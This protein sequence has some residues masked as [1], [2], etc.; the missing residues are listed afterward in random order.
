MRE[1]LGQIVLK[2]KMILSCDYGAAGDN[3]PAM[4]KPQTT[5]GFRR[6]FIERTRWARIGR[7]Y[8]QEEAASLL[9]LPQDKYKQYESRSLLPHELIAKFC[10]LCA[11]DEGWLFT[12]KGRAPA[13]PEPPRKETRPRP[14]RRR[15]KAA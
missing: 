5:T 7:G 6:D 11:I 10:L 8:T 12:A 9:G 13:I 3:Y 1:S 14:F 2:R 15:K 4:P